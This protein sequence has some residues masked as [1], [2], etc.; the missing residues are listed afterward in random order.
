MW[1]ISINDQILTL[2][3][4]LCLGVILCVYY[5]IFRAFHKAG[6]DSP[7]QVFIGDI[8][9]CVTA[10]FAT[11]LFLLSRT[12]GEIRGYVLVTALVGF[13]ITRLT[14]SKLTF[15]LLTKTLLFIVTTLRFLRLNILRFLIVSG[16][17]T[18][19]F[20]KNSQKKASDGLKYIKKLLKSIAH[21]LYTK[22]NNDGVE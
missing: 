3:Y 19:R 2:L 22:E 5:D 6:F 16:R 14:L 1:E 13:I 21:L 4:S 10:A 20:L 8:L 7:F 12:N 18:V 9:Y 11:F 17:Y 15:F